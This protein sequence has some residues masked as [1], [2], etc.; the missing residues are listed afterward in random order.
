MDQGWWSSTIAEAG[1]G[2]HEA[3]QCAIS[4][5]VVAG[6]QIQCG[7]QVHPVISFVP[8]PQGASVMALSSCATKTTAK[9]DMS[10][11]SFDASF[12]T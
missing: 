3:R 11:R 1:Q 10:T 7:C 6:R 9:S 2:A 5:V 12:K 4:G 8:V